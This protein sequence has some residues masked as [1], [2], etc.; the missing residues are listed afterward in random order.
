M[1]LKEYARVCEYQV[2]PQFSQRLEFLRYLPMTLAY[3]FTSVE[4]CYFICKIRTLNYELQ[5]PFQSK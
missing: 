1:T 3:H 2:T 4:L 5:V